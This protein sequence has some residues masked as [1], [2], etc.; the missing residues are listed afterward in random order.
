MIKTKIKQEPT[1]RHY[2]RWFFLALVSIIGIGIFFAWLYFQKPSSG[3]IKIV[4]SAAENFS[5]E[6][7]FER[8][9]GK[10]FSFARDSQYILKSHIKNS[11]ETG[12]VLESAFFAQGGINS[13]KIAV[14]IE[15]I[16][17]RTM[18]DTGNFIMRKKTPETYKEEKFEISGI[19]GISFSMTTE[20]GFFDKVYFI[21]R[22]GYVVEISFTA[23]ITNDD[24]L[25]GEML[26]V[27]KSIQWKM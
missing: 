5:I 14:T 20:A 13:K 15:N 4:P 1:K 25:A 18:A 2:L 21:P 16:E 8:F 17:G 24:A 7:S 3:E 10:Y 6:N 23:P 11:E 26:E 9:E 27:V 19:E 12:V 22:D